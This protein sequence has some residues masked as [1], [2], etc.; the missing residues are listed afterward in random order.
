VGTLGSRSRQN[1]QNAERKTLLHQ[2]SQSD[3]IK[4]SQ[5]SDSPLTAFPFGAFCQVESEI[6]N[7]LIWSNR[8]G[9]WQV[10]SGTLRLVMFT[11]TFWMFWTALILSSNVEV[12]RGIYQVR[13]TELLELLELE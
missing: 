1:A 9:W 3:Q 13:R 11:L 10:F 8:E 2:P 5:I 4:R 7:R 6:L 12:Q